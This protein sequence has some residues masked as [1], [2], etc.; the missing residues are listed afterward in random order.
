MD[1]IGG[2]HLIVGGICVCGLLVDQAGQVGQ[3][4]VTNYTFIADEW[5]TIIIIELLL[6]LT[7]SSILSGNRAGMNAKL[8][9]LRSSHRSHVT[10]TSRPD[11]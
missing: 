1:S 11:R 2:G 7:T 8:T 10:A 9:I 3:L 5:I 4:G 6:F